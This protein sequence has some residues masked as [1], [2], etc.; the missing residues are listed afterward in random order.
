[1]TAQN[2]T[3]IK[4]MIEYHQ[5]Y[6][7]GMLIRL[8]WRVVCKGCAKILHLDTKTRLRVTQQLLLR[9]KWMLK[10]QEQGDTVGVWYCSDCCPPSVVPKET[11]DE[12]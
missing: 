3:P 12:C 11:A 8:G 5:R 4:T 10:Q 2:D 7:K 1:M 6:S 9:H